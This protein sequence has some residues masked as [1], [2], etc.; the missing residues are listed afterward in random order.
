MQKKIICL[1]IL[2]FFGKIAKLFSPL[3]SLKMIIKKQSHAL[4]IWFSESDSCF[5]VL[6]MGIILLM[7]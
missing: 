2:N 1:T 3:V 7:F 6:L 4:G 5:Y